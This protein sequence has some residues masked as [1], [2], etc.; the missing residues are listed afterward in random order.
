M[1]PNH[2]MLPAALLAT[3]S[4]GW[5]LLL[6]RHQVNP[7]A[8]ADHLLAVPEAAVTV[9]HD[10]FFAHEPDK[11]PLLL[12]L[13]AVP[14]I[15]SEQKRQWAQLGADGLCQSLISGGNTLVSG[16]LYATQ[17]LAQITRHLRQLFAH[18]HPDGQTH[19]LRYYDP[20]ITRLLDDTL[21]TAQ[22][23][24][25]LGPID[26]WWYPVFPGEYRSM[27]QQ[28][29]DHGTA[30]LVL[31]P[32]HWQRLDYAAAYHQLVRCMAGLHELY[33]DTFGSIVVPDFALVHSLMSRAAQQSWVNSQDDQVGCALLW[34]VL[35][36]DCQACNPD[37]A[38]ALQQYQ[39]DRSPALTEWLL[40]A[41][42]A[43]WAK[44]AADYTASSTK[45]TM[46]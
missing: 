34:L 33:P 24:Q 4:P 40:F 39:Q 26:S 9:L 22:R 13:S 8:D 12:D 5:Y 23:Q 25:L 43:F 6:D 2:Y 3:E 38:A 29:G 21:P 20:R 28:H 35:G 15:S 45:G 10:P 17:P 41:G 19:H 11:A 7:L 14:G 30:S 46:A 42:A 16:W 44:P 27:Q 18:P 36:P 37:V 1:D 31:A 32:E